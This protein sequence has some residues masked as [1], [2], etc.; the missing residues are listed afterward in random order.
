MRKSRDSVNA[1]LLLTVA[2]K[3]R[4]IH[5]SK[6]KLGRIVSTGVIALAREAILLIPLDVAA[7]VGVFGQ[8][9]ATEELEIEVVV[10]LDVELRAIGGFGGEALGVG[11]RRRGR[12]AWAGPFQCEGGGDDAEGEG[13]EEC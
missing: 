9:L 6:T 10:A 8:A 5:T 7:R 12:C 13:E 2:K 1:N 3:G 11:E 4:K